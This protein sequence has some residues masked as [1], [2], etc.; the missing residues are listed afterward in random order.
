M[1]QDRQ[2]ARPVSR[3]SWSV[4]RLFQGR[5]QLGEVQLLIDLDQKV[6]GIDEIP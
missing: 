3:K 5:H 2:D 1:G 4:I 6:I